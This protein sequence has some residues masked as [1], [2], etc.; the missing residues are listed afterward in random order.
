MDD[1]LKIALGL[2]VKKNI[3]G[4]KLLFTYYFNNFKANNLG[5][6]HNRNIFIV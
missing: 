1:L 2:N 5:L 3:S 6:T 4:R